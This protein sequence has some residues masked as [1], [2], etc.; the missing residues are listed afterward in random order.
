MRLAIAASLLI[1]VGL[2]TGLSWDSAKSGAVNANAVNHS[3]RAARYE[4][5]SAYVPENLAVT[6][7]RAMVFPELTLALG[8][9]R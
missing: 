7:E 1:G 6:D 9:G 8:T 2:G 4:Y 3:S 5:A